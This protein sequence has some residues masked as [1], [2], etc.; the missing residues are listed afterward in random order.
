V[1]GIVAPDRRHDFA[2]DPVELFFDLAYVFAFSRLVYLLLGDPT[3]NGFGEFVLLFLLVWL[4]WMQFTWAVN[5]VSATTRTARILMLVATVASVPMAGSIPAALG[6]GGP[7]FAISLGVIL[8]MALLA[9]ISG[10]PRGSTVRGSIIEYSVPNWIAIVVVV[11][12]S[13][14]DDAVRVGLWIAAIAIIVAGTVRAGR[15]EW[16]VR[17]KHFAERHGL[18]VIVA[19]GELIVAVGIAV[20]AAVTDDESGLPTET[21][22][23][24]VLAGVFACT[25]WWGVFDRP[26]PA[27][28]HRHS[29]HDDPNVAGR[30]ARDVYTY[31]HMP[32][33]GGLVICAAAIEEISLHPSDRLEAGF[34]WLLIGG[35]AIHL[36]GIVGAVWRAFRVLAVERLVGAALVGL[37]VVALQRADGLVVLAAVDVV[38]LAVLAFEHRRVEAKPREPGVDD[39]GGAER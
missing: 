12:G 8:A 4:P 5:A 26:L 34:V 6:D 17:P 29:Q 28:E 9:M 22:A 7:T 39:T 18:I 14:L 30:F 15:R 21:I 27:F 38:L 33:V 3:W 25:M 2:A 19:L 37:A 32:I 20:V 1:K 24:L 10:L 23:A 11:V 35:V 36:G 16:L 31:W 13:L